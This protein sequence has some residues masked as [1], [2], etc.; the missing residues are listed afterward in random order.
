VVCATAGR[1]RLAKATM[2]MTVRL[3]VTGILWLDFP[4]SILSLLEPK[5]IN[6]GTMVNRVDV[7]IG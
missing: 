5:A 2:A 3:A 7:P 6:T 1:I 4:R